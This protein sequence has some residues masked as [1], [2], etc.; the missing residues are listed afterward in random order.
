MTAAEPYWNRVSEHCWAWI[1]PD[2]SWFVNNAAIVADGA[3]LVAVDTLAS[4][5][6]TRRYRAAIEE[7]FGHQVRTIITTHHHGDHS[8]GNFLF[9]EAAIVGQHRTRRGILAAGEPPG[10]EGRPSY[11]PFDFGEIEL[12]PPTI[13]FTDELTVWAG[14]VPCQVNSV[15]EVAHTADDSYVHLADEG[16]LITGD[17]IFSGGTPFVLM[18]SLSGLERCLVEQLRPLGA[19]VLVPG[20]GPVGGPELIEDVLEHLR[21]LQRLAADGRR[22]GLSPL[23]TARSADLGRF[24]GWTDTERIVGNLHRAYAEADGLPAGEPLDYGAIIREMVQL[25]G[26]RRIEVCL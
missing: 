21:W 5:P 16:V 12:S 9:P 8:Y 3:Q 6:R 25:R 7:K 15:G 1:Q 10:P 22:R 11:T 17:L 20:H 14:E 23:E 4:V 18:G 2:G 24:A 19:S 13:C 26:G